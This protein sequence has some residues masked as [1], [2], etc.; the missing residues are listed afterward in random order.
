[1]DVKPADMEGQLYFVIKRKMILKK[2]SQITYIKI[3]LP[4]IPYLPFPI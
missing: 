4:L 1:M 3:Y 2:E